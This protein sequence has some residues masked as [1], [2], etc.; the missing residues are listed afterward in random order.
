MLNFDQ[1]EQIL[2][3][4]E[5]SKLLRVSPQWVYAHANGNRLPQRPSKK[6]GGARRFVYR[7]VMAFVAECA[8]QS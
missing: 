4:P 1:Q 2:T 5:V 7:E 6:L 3:A 8:Q